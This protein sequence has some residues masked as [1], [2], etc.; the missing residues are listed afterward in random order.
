MARVSNS[1][2]R[3]RAVIVLVF[4]AGCVESSRGCEPGWQSEQEQ[5]AFYDSTVIKGG[6]GYFSNDGPLLVG[7]V[8]CPRIDCVRPEVEDEDNPPLD[9]CP[10]NPDENHS[11]V[12]LLACFDQEVF[13]A[14]L[15]G[16][17]VNFDTPGSAV[18]A[19]TPRNCDAT[20]GGFTPE[21]DQV[22]Y[23]VVDAEDV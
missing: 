20:M 1:R 18:W 23:D 13:G 12:A 7:T 11:N 17:C 4:A 15:V 9:L 2:T 16:G 10:T 14:S 6:E 21:S 19:F 22:T 5:I 8:I 3:T